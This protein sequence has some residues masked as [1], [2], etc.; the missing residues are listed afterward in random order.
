MNIRLYNSEKHGEALKQMYQAQGFE[1]VFPNFE[2]PEFFTRLV[3]EDE[4]RPVMA[5]M[6]RL[7]AEM[8]LLMDPEAGSPGARLRNFLMLH[9]ASEFDMAKKGIQDCYAQIP[10]GNKMEKFKRLLKLLGW[11]KANTWEPWTKPQLSTRPLFP[12][13]FR[14]LLG[15][16]T[17]GTQRTST[18]SGHEPRALQHTE[19]VHS[20]GP[21]H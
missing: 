16:G 5:I 9:Q 10:P 12:A 3:L 20:S 11:V 2:H 18:S 6:G 4:G 8:Y 15:R 19:G 21:G 14:K 17:D 13:L 7:T 1:Y